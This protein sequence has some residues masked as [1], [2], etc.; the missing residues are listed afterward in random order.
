MHNLL[1]IPYD[2]QKVM[3]IDLFPTK[4]IFGKEGNISV[5]HK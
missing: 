4:I 3:Q 5:E 1:V 2:E